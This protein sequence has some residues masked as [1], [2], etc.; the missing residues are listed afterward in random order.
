[1][2]NNKKIEGIMRKIEMEKYADKI[3]EVYNLVNQLKDKI[4]EI[5]NEEVRETTLYAT[6]GFLIET[7][8]VYYAVKITIL[9]TVK[10][11]L[12]RMWLNL[13]KELVEKV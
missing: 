12:L 13:Y 11:E 5:N 6:I 10:L 8:H 2:S 3:K 7:T 4:N 9:E 1:M